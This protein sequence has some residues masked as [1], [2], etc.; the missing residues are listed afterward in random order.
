MNDDAPRAEGPTR[1]PCQQF[2]TEVAQ[3]IEAG[4]YRDADAALIQLGIPEADRRE[5]LR[6][7]RTDSR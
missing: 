2:Y 7:L 1:S 5:M 6:D 4:N 3:Q